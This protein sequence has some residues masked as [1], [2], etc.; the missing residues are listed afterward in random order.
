MIYTIANPQR[1]AIF[2]PTVV[3]N[4][5]TAF[6]ALSPKTIYAKAAAGT[7]PSVKLAGSLCFDCFVVA[8]WLPET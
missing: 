5:V 8:D 3:R 6:P 4:V 7:I 1:L 2:L